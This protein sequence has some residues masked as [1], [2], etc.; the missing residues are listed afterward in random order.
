MPGTTPDPPGNEPTN[1]PPNEP[2]VVVPTTPTGEL[3]QLGPG[4]PQLGLGRGSR[5]VIAV[6]GVL[7][8]IAIAVVGGIVLLGRGDEAKDTSTDTDS[9]T[10]ISEPTEKAPSSLDLPTIDP[11][12]FPTDLPTIE[13]SELTE[14]PDDFPTTF[15][16]LPSAF[17]TDSEGWEEWLSDNLEQANP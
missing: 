11:S 10:S 14:L 13:P 9:D 7:L 3:P 1:E 5:I 2:T 6:G 17:P 16:D 8:L 15:L 4:G 12:D